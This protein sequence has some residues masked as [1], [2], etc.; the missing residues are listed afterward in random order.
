M[1]NN[2][3]ILEV[4]EMTKAEEHELW[5]MTPAERAAKYNVVSWH[6]DDGNNEIRFGGEEFWRLICI[7][8]G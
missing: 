8:E 4:V 3:R 5:N 6:T 2:T 1:K 7:V